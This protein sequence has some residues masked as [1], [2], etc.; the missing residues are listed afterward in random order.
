VFL[1]TSIIEL[2]GIAVVGQTPGIR[3][4]GIRVVDVTSGARPGFRS[5]VRRWFLLT[6]LGFLPELGAGAPLL[7][8]AWMLRSPLRQGLHDIFAG[9]IVITD[10]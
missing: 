6:A 10:P 5:S 8:A 3:Y 9:T 4:V 1:A 2:V 7:G